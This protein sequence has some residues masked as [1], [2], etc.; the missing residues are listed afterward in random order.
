MNP[1]EDY[2][3]VSLSSNSPDNFLTNLENSSVAFE[4]RRMFR[5][6]LR[7]VRAEA[8]IAKGAIGPSTCFATAVEFIGAHVPRLPA[9]SLAVACVE[10]EVAR[11][12]HSRLLQLLQDVRVHWSRGGGRMSCAGGRRDD[13]R[14]RGVSRDPGG[15]DRRCAPSGWSGAPEGPRAA[16]RGEERNPGAREGARGYARRR[17]R[18]N[19]NREGR[20]SWE[21]P[22]R[23]VCESV[24]ASV[25]P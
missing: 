9:T 1:G 24:C 23:L 17:R 18:G 12:T 10:E 16:R 8:V 5:E 7:R 11:W 21:R 13:T 4:C 20:L 22:R 14:P 3:A 19:E 6:I 25:G 15:D 2:V